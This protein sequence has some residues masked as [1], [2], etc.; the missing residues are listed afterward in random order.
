MLP[1][2]ESG[3][4]FRIFQNEKSQ[5]P[6]LW[7]SW[8]VPFAR[9]TNKHAINRRPT[10]VTLAKDASNGKNQTIDCA[11]PLFAQSLEQRTNSVL[12]THSKGSSF[13]LKD[14]RA[15]QK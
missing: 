5:N 11:Q 1:F 10:E 12:L 3:Q 13:F 4:D 2:Q 14:E 9:M 8:N 6:T 15:L 7:R